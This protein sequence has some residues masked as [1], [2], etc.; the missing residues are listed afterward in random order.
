MFVFPWLSITP[1]RDE[2]PHIIIQWWPFFLPDSPRNHNAGPSPSPE[3]GSWID[4]EKS[5]RTYY[6]SNLSN[7]YVRPVIFFSNTWH[8]IYPTFTFY[9]QDQYNIYACSLSK[10]TRLWDSAEAVTQTSIYMYIHIL[11]QQVRY[12]GPVRT[13]LINWLIKIMSLGIYE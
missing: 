1:V 2:I 8:Y 6:K 5:H 3:T 9:S 12:L 7:W 10:R 4:P 11:H 13:R